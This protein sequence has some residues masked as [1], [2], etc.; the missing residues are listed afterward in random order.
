MTPWSVRPRA[1]WPNAAARAARPSMLAAPSSSEYSE[2]TCRCAQAW[3]LTE[4]TRL[5]AGSDASRAPRTTSPHAAAVLCSRGLC[6]V[7]PRLQ[8]RHDLAVAAHDRPVAGRGRLAPEQMREALGGHRHG[9]VRA[10]LRRGGEDLD[11]AVAD[12]DVPGGG[13][14]GRDAL[15]DREGVLARPRG[16]D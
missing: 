7:Q 15:G 5:G 6:A 16:V 13:R 2:W 9:R 10:R 8:Q 1:G 14:V 4:S 12:R 11:A 3:V